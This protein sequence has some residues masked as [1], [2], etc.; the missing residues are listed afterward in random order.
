[1]KF[2]KQ[3]NI[4]TMPDTLLDT[5]RPPDKLTPLSIETPA[6]RLSENMI[7][8]PIL[9]NISSFN[10]ELEEAEKAMFEE[11][12][13]LTHAVLTT[14]NTDPALKDNMV[15]A[16]ED[17]MESEKTRKAMEIE[18]RRSEALRKAYEAVLVD[19][20]TLS[21][22]LESHGSDSYV[23]LNRDR[24]LQ[25]VDSHEFSSPE[26]EDAIREL[27]G[28]LC[29]T[30]D[31][32]ND[33]QR[34]VRMSSPD[35]SVA[36]YPETGDIKGVLQ[37]EGWSQTNAHGA[38]IFIDYDERARSEDAR[39]SIKLFDRGGD[40]AAVT[41]TDNL[42]Y[43]FKKGTEDGSIK[44]ADLL[45]AASIVLEETNTEIVG[46]NGRYNEIR[47]FNSPQ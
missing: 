20:H 25:R 46:E 38:V 36:E 40:S 44:P 39:V 29:E 47:H 21:Q 28:L 5:L 23:D 3:D 35:L 24:L 14:D 18:S 30:S 27:F 16:N 45:I 6:P 31:A 43:R 11:T 22:D 37:V 17:F 7:S 33:I 41:A 13:R 19:T 8:T 9:R 15:K 12:M 4:N 1:M 32:E 10:L 42:A 2:N 34:A 26:A